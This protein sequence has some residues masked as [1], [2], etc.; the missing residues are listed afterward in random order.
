MQL[1]LW[2]VLCDLFYH[3]CLW[4]NK[5]FVTSIHPSA[6]LTGIDTCSCNVSTDTTAL[7]QETHL[8]EDHKYKSFSLYKHLNH[9]TSYIST[10]NLQGELDWWSISHSK[11]L[12]YRQVFFCLVVCGVAPLK[13]NKWL[14]FWGEDSLV[15][16]WS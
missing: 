2:F 5:T 10:N 3:S 11:T 15:E 8:C 12:L 9:Y 7:T 13:P 4:Q 14:L 16:Q 1:L 6:P